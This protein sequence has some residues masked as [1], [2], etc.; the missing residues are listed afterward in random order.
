MIDKRINLSD[1]HSKIV[2]LT[3]T[4]LVLRRVAAKLGVDRTGLTRYCKR[5]GIEFAVRRTIKGCAEEV[6]AMAAEGK[7]SGEIAKRLGFSTVTVLNWCSDNGV[8]LRDSYH[9]GVIVAKGKYI[10]V[11]VPGHPSADAKGY[12]RLHRLMIEA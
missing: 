11:Q 8:L 3:R 10:M 7:S 1:L 2:R 4:G 6:R 12:V 9:A 5:H